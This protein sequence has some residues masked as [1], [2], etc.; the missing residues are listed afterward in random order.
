ML[1][2]GRDSSLLEKKTLSFYP[3]LITIVRQNAYTVWQAVKIT[4]KCDL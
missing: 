4:D 3:G 1:F 2:T